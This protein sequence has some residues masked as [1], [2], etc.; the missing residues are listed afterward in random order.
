MALAR[1]RLREPRPRIDMRKEFWEI[2]VEI[3]V[4]RDDQRRRRL[5]D[6]VAVGRAGERR[7][8]VLGILARCPDKPSGLLIGEVGPIFTNS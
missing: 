1:N 3:L 8:F 2:F 6:L 5:A 7:Q 4:I